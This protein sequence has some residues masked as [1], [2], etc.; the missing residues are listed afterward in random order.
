M[1]ELITIENEKNISIK[2]ATKVVSS[3]PTQAVVLAENSTIVICGSELEVKKLDIENK[4]VSLA[5]MITS[6]KFSQK[7]EKQPFFK[8]IF[9]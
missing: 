6:I 1:Q 8:R 7:I 5:G 2:G 3:T 4:E 9:K